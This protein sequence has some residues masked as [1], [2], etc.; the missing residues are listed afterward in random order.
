MSTTILDKK[1]I[2]INGLEFDAIA[3]T[4]Q[5]NILKSHA[6][7]HVRLLFLQFTGIEMD[8]KNWIKNL[9]TGF[10]TILP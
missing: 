2:S 4:L 10:L 8:V 6:R 5:S 9:I 3:P 7:D 1:G